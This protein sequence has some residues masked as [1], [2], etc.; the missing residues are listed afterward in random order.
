LARKIAEVAEEL[1]S[2]GPSDGGG[3]VA[4]GQLLQ[5]TEFVEPAWLGARLAC[6]GES[7]TVL[8]CG[9]IPVV[10]AFRGR[11]HLTTATPETVIAIVGAA[12]D[13][14]TFAA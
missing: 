6:R 10:T 14:V 2:L 13:E 1:D 7:L 4:A 8:T 5:E 3:S 11:A 12:A 9:L